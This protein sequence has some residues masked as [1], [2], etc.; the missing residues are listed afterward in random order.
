[1]KAHQRLHTIPVSS[2]LPSSFQRWREGHSNAQDFDLLLSF[3]NSTD[4][5]LSVYPTHISREDFC[6]YFKSASRFSL[7]GDPDGTRRSIHLQ[8]KE[9]VT[10]RHLHL[11]VKSIYSGSIELS[12]ADLECVLHIATELQVPALRD[13]CLAH[14]CAHLSAI[15]PVESYILGNTYAESRIKSAVLTVLCEQLGQWD[16]WRWWGY[17]VSLLNTPTLSSKDALNLLEKRMPRVSELQLLDILCQCGRGEALLS[18]VNFC[19]LHPCEVEALVRGVSALLYPAAAVFAQGRQRKKTKR[20]AH[21]SK[22][23]VALQVKEGKKPYK[24]LTTALTSPVIEEEVCSPFVELCNDSEVAESRQTCQIPFWSSVLARLTEMI[25]NPTLLSS[26]ED[27]FFWKLDLGRLEEHSTL[28]SGSFTMCGLELCMLAEL[29]EGDEKTS[30]DIEPYI[31]VKASSRVPLPSSRRFRVTF[32]TLSQRSFGQVCCINV[33]KPLEVKMAAL[34]AGKGKSIY[35]NEVDRQAHD[36]LVYFE[37]GRELMTIG[38][39]VEE[40]AQ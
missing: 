18:A 3:A 7:G 28:R 34:V 11:V 29:W 26:L 30:L 6:K 40:I 38:V 25:Y 5:D 8:L 27:R 33:L 2:M 23:S 12:W 10:Q 17:L 39:K 32:F 24:T 16:D 20:S 14:V 13:A 21:S 36:S 1:M 35:N 22:K 15:Y 9:G 19:R 31:F 37:S 4:L